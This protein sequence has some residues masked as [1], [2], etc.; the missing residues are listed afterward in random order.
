M[1]IEHIFANATV[2]RTADSAAE[3]SINSYLTT[4]MP[5][6]SQARGCTEIRDR[7]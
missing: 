7:S 2:V 4:K 6:D 5:V 3:R 1:Q